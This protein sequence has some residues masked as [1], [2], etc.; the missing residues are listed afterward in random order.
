MRRW[1]K[2]YRSQWRRVGLSAGASIVAAV[3]EASSLVLVISLANHLASDR[4][5][6]L[7]ERLGF[8]VVAMSLGQAVALTLALV[9]GSVICHITAARLTARSVADLVFRWRTELISGFLAMPYAYQVAQ[10]GG[11]VQEV[12]GQQA[13]TAA[14]ALGAF[15]TAVNAGFSVLILTTSAFAL[16][17]LAALILVGGGGTILFAIRPII[18]RVRQLGAQEADLDIGFGIEVNEM[19]AAVRDTKIFNVQGSFSMSAHDLAAAAAANQRR[20]A[21][22]GA[23]VPVVYQ[24]AG[25]LLLL[26]V[27]A[28]ASFVEGVTITTLAGAALLLYRGLGYGQRL[29]GMQQQLARQLPYAQVVAD[30][31]SAYR[32]HPEVFGSQ[33]LARVDRIEF[34][35]VAYAYSDGEVAIKDVSFGIEGPGI[36]GLAGSSGSG[37][38]TVAQLLLRLRQPD[39]GEIRVNDSPHREYSRERWSKEVSFV[40]QEAYLIHATVHENIAYFRAN[41]TREQVIEAAKSVGLHNHISLLPA[42]YDT[43][44]GPSVRDF[45]GGQRQRI[46]IARAL[47]GQP[48][49]LVLDEPTSALDSETEG[50]VLATLDALRA[51]TIV[52]VITHRASTLELCNRVIQLDNGTLVSVG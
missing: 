1:L 35:K 43:E 19:S 8:I 27:L 44:L 49:L 22:L 9:L 21:S 34:D 31:L 36:V 12:A 23:A 29:S 33:H 20:L 11:E 25:H 52:I 45:S 39:T 10:R 37:K 40:P 3:T 15:T 48:S 42:G 24:G 41:I 18:R 47:V 14:A 6:P 5:G 38:S 17:P 51:S 26:G 32:S 13:K 46:G 30:H 28:I 7:R 4:Q 2:F 50:W 16:D